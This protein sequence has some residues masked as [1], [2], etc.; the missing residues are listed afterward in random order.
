MLFFFS[1]TSVKS[2]QSVNL[3]DDDDDEIIVVYDKLK[4]TNGDVN[5]RKPNYGSVDSIPL[6]PEKFDRMEIN[7]RIRLEDIPLPPS[8]N[9]YD[10]LLTGS[11]SELEMDAKQIKKCLKEFRKWEHTDL[12][13]SLLQRGR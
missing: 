13:K 10:R 3:S 11:Q 7:R 2:I 12:G 4:E 9:S 8:P 5:P 1:G 6:P